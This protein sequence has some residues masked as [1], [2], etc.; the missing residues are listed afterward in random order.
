MG[1]STLMRYRTQRMGTLLGV[2]FQVESMLIFLGL[3]LRF[4]WLVSS[5]L[6]RLLMPYTGC[7][8]I[9]GEGCLLIRPRRLVSTLRTIE[10][11]QEE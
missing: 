4:C 6:P 5:S 1:I 3:S 11:V 2:I 8:W 9:R 7:V 10:R